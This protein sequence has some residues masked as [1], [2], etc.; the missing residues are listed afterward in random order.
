MNFEAFSQNITN[1]DLL[2]NPLFWL[3]AIL[4]Q[5]IILLLYYPVIEKRINFIGAKLFGG[6]S[7]AIYYIFFIGTV[8]HELSHLLACL[9]LFVRVGKVNFF[10]PEK[11]KTGEGMTLGYVQHE[12]TDPFRGTLIGMAPIFGCA[13][14]TYLT[15]TWVVPSLEF[16]SL[17]TIS[18]I[19]DGFK[20][21]FTNPFNW[22]TLVF[23]YVVI[24]CAT[25]GNPSKSDLESLPV[26]LII[27]GLIGGGVFLIKESINWE[28]LG[29]AAS[30]AVFLTPPFMVI[31]IIMAFELFILGM[32]Q[33]TTGFIMRRWGYRAI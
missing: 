21:I 29:E 32:I 6:N 1:S 17:P 18:A 13:L 9:M 28:F 4:V 11:S 25:A 2:S 20:Y 15:F 5:F 27:L 23:F 26:A 22:K 24:A 33:L 12:V 10:G 16:F 8:I 14:F 31:A 3:S 30:N 19:V 7:M